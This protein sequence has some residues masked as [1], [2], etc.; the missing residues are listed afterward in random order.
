MVYS[1]ER[2][3]P[4][5]GVDLKGKNVA[6]ILFLT[7]PMMNA[8][9]EEVDRARWAKAG[10]LYTDPIATDTFPR[11]VDDLLESCV[12][13]WSGRDGAHRTESSCRGETLRYVCKPLRR[14]S[15]EIFVVRRQTP[16]FCTTI[17]A[18]TNKIA[19]APTEIAI[20][21]HGNVWVK[22]GE[23]APMD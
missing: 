5:T 1:G 16:L 19:D 6:Q 4:S 15:P 10:T 3:Y 14:I 22:S 12:Q 8:G 13:K 7:W 23:D 2:E 11:P 18:A 21:A 17:N 20:L 9:E